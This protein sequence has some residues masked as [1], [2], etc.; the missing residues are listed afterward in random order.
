MEV[1]CH[2]DMGADCGRS[3]P[4]AHTP[5]NGQRPCSRSSARCRTPC[6]ARPSPR[7]LAGEPQTAV[8]RLSPNTPSKASFPPFMGGKCYLCVRYNVSPMSQVAHRL[9]DLIP[10]VYPCACTSSSNGVGSI[11]VQNPRHSLNGAPL[12]VGNGV[13]VHGE[14]CL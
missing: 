13:S 9:R 14:S 1:G 8:F 11:Q 7:R 6:K 12:R 5:D 2:S 10:S 4:A 3:A